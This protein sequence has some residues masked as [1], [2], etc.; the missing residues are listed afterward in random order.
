MNQTAIRLPA[1][2]LLLSLTPHTLAA[3]T[4]VNPSFEVD[5]YT[6]WPGAVGQNGGKLTGWKHTGT[7][8]LNPVWEDPTKPAESRAPFA[9]NGRPPHG[10]QVAFIHNIGAL[11]QMIDG[12]EAGKKYRLTYFENARHNNAPDRNPK[13]RVTFGG[14]VLVS[15]HALKPVEA[16]DSH[17]LPFCFVESAVFTA[18]KAGAFELRFETTFG[19]RVAI[20]LDQVTIAEVGLPPPNTASLADPFSRC[21]ST[22][23]SGVPCLQHAPSCRQVRD[24]TRWPSRYRGIRR[25]DGDD[26]LLPQFTVAV[27]RRL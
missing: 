23:E 12:F 19:D 17:T 4:V 16:I 25:G 7:V 5:R 6:V 22:W 10:R 21:S 3:P 2:A 20:V 27:G 18:P 15:E 26:C 24:P 13:L 14:E 9:D 11:S 8:G 1:L